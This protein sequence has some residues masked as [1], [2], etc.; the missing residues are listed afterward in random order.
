M[1]KND[2]VF[3]TIAVNSSD[4]VL[5][6]ENFD[7]RQ[8]GHALASIFNDLLWRTLETEHIVNPHA[9]R[10]TEDALQVIGP[11]EQIFNQPLNSLSSP[12]G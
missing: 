12:Y 11:S 3:L 10:R 8:R 4:S 9:Q 7:L 2:M 6:R 1:N 5:M